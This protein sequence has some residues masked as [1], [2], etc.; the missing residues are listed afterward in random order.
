M[1]SAVEQ[2]CCLYP[3][4]KL[5]DMDCKLP[6]SNTG[7]SLLRITSALK[8]ISTRVY[9]DLQP[10]YPKSRSNTGIFLGTMLVR[11]PCITWYCLG[12]VPRLY[13]SSNG[14]DVAPTQFLVP[15]HVLRKVCTHLSFESLYTSSTKISRLSLLLVFIDRVPHA[16]QE[17]TKPVPRS[18]GGALKPLVH[19]VQRIPLHLYLSQHGVVFLPRAHSMLQLLLRSHAVFTILS[20][21]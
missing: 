14:V 10:R 20:G 19:R 18:P 2:S 15:H 8:S 12:M 11:L 17:H 16:P 6:I 3:H 1:S 7:V 13:R 21:C 4:I 5:F 9:R